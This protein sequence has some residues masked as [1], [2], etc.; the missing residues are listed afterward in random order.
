MCGI[1]GCI[2]L[3]D[4]FFSKEDF[5][6]ATNLLNNRGPDAF[7]VK[8][9]ILNRFV[10]KLGHQRLS[11]LGIDK[12]G[13]QPM[14]SENDLFSIIYN[15]E[16]YNHNF[17]RKQLSST[18]NINWKSS[19]DTETLLNL[20]EYEGIDSILN[21]I[22]GMFS[23][24]LFDRINQKLI[25]A[26][27]RSGE[28]PLYLSTGE[29]F[30]GFAS[31]LSPLKEIPGFCSSLDKF[32]TQKYLQHNYIPSPLSVYEKSFKLPPGSYISIDLNKYK[33]KPCSSFEELIQSE[34]VYFKLW[35]SLDEGYENKLQNLSISDQEVIDET[36]SLLE[37]SVNKQL[38]SDVPL[39]AFLSGGIDSS[40]VVAMMQKNGRESKTY[41]VGFDFAD[42]DESIYAEKI[43]NYLGSN[44]TTYTCNKQDVLDIIPQLPR[45]FSEPFADSSQI[46]TML[47]SRLARQDVKVALSGDAGDELFGGYNRY[48]IANKYWRYLKNISPKI[49]K[50]GLTLLNRIPNNILSFLFYFSPFSRNLSGSAEVR[51]LKILDKLKEINDPESFYKSMTVEWKVQSNIMN[52]D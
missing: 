37:A 45:A 34:G 21:K 13:D 24:C 32:A 10:L 33:P 19:C 17:L 31:D 28:K 46:P 52:F 27:D 22:E 8:E 51:V 40:L 49:R 18:S 42:Y 30:L 3:K 4:F 11:I 12:F 36:E 1:N 48:L 35:W 47:V 16:I 6:S 44:H 39:G 15:G 7:G 23:F 43:A 5:S 29:S 9:T 20:F 14:T 38:I 50:G 25:L 2:H 41:T 26:R